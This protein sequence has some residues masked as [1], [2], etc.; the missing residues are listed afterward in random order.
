MRTWQGLDDS[1]T[2]RLLQMKRMADLYFIALTVTLF[3]LS[4]AMVRVFGR[5]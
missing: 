5:M 3:A 2:C 1:L 4:L